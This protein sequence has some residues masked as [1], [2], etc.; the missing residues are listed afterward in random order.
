MGDRESLSREIATLREQ[1]HNMIQK[2]DKYHAKRVVSLSCE[3]DDKIVEFMEL[4][5]HEEQ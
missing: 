4:N 1:L 2:R 5:T 3:L